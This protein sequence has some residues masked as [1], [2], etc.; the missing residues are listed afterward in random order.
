LHN[1]FAIAM[2]FLF[3]APREVNI[4]ALEVLKHDEPTWLQPAVSVVIPLFNETDN[5]LP[6]YQRLRAAMDDAGRTWEVIFID[7]GSRDTTFGV[8]QELHRQDDR[9][10]VVRLRRNFGQT[11]ALAAGF[12]AARGAMIVSLDGDLQNDPQDIAA[13]LQK[14]DEGYDV[15][16]GWRVHRRE[17][18]WLRRLPSHVANWLISQ[19]T[20]IHLHDYGCTLKAYRAEMVKELRLYGEMHRFIP[21]LLG[22]NGARIAELPVQHRPRLHGRS[23]Y[24]LSRTV[25]V[26]LD[27]VTVKFWL[28]SLTSPLQFFGL[29]GL[30]TGGAG[31][32]MCLYLAS[33]KLFWEYSL[34][35]RPLL[36][37][38]I[39]LMVIGVQFLCVGILAE[40][41]IRTYHE[42]SKKPV[43][44]IREILDG[45]SPEVCT[46]LPQ[47]I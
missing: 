46:E 24:G 36:L 22:G 13:L 42:S 28:S 5:I 12:E 37:L 31:I 45:H 39:L 33:L 27:L 3:F 32:A 7:D 47:K 23:K 34:T 11:A 29:I 25:R 44:A 38:G 8:L 15:V 17:S 6:L 41:Q 20:G 14:L 2:E 1:L 30:V 4:M 9:V 26:L 43:Y 10:R 35:D 19:T 18:F 40:I 21:A 16:S